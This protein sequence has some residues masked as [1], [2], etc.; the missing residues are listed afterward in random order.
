MVQRFA[1][2]LAVVSVL[3][4][5]AVP[6]VLADMMLCSVQ[7]VTEC[8]NDEECGPPNFGARKPATFFLIDTDRKVATL[9][10]PE[11]RRGETTEIHS[12]VETPNGWLLAGVENERS[13]SLWLSNNGDVTLS[14]TMDGATWSGFGKWM[15]AK[16]VEP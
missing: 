4:L 2:V 12:Q 11:E 9:L 1:L 15:P 14:I 13:W 16:D 10:A 8:S 7:R 6:T 3:T 5:T